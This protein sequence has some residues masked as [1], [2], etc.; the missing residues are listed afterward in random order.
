MKQTSD[1]RVM[2]AAFN[3][4]NLRLADQMNG[5]GI[6]N[7]LDYAII[8]GLGLG[9]IYGLSRGGLRMITSLLSL[10]GALYAASVYH[11]AA[12]KLVN[13]QLGV[14][15][16]TGRILGYV[17]AFV[18]V[19]IAIELTGSFVIRM[20]RLV[21]MGWIDRLIGAATGAAVAG[22]ILGITIVAMMLI[23][24][25]RAEILK[26]SVLAPDLLAYNQQLLTL[27]PPELK[28]K[29]Q[30]RSTQFLALWKQQANLRR[31]LRSEVSLPRSR[32]R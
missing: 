8:A 16:T 12:S 19:F 32:T 6:L 26:N 24:P 20:V 31:D 15:S 11:E 3:R 28:T 30:A 13:R 2:R 1:Y 23:L 29:Y 10:M 5:I 25:A 21:N 22:I 7:G 4:A 14:N 9:A 18:M 17:A 27:V